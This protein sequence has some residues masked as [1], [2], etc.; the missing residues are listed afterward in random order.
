MNDRENQHQPHADMVDQPRDLQTAEQRYQEIE[1]L[2][3]RTRRGDHRVEGKTGADQDQIK[4][5]EAGVSR[6]GKCIVARIGRGTMPD[7]QKE[8]GRSQILA[9]RSRDR[10]IS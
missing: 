5:E 7:E 4:E 2:E 8:Q 3:W 9:Q 6:T 10:G 1:N